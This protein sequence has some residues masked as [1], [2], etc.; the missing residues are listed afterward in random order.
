[1]QQRTEMTDRVTAIEEW[2]DNHDARCEE[3]Q[4]GIQASLAELKRTLNLQG[5]AAWGVV[6]ALLAWA[7]L[8]V[9]T[10]RDQSMAARISALERPPAVSVAVGPP[11]VTK[12]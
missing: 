3:R 8:N 1:M 4:Q 11:P 12:P 5:K 9:W 6:V 10:S 7:M 2:R